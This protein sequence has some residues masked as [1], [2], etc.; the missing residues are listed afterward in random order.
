MFPLISLLLVLSVW[1]A[2]IFQ[3]IA[4]HFDLI[5]FS[6]GARS[7]RA[8]MAGVFGSGSVPFPGMGRIGSSPPKNTSGVMRNGDGVTSSECGRPGAGS[9]ARVAGAC[10]LWPISGGVQV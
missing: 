9:A 1:S 7:R 4:N 8:I 10:P 6:L 3:K 5:P 2:R